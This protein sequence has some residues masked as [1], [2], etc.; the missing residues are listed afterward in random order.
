MFL[1]YELE[2]D[3]MGLKVQPMSVTI[4]KDKQNLI[5]ISIGGGAPH[6]PCLFV[7][8]VFDNTPAAKVGTLESG[9]E[10][11]SIQTQSVKG[12]SKQE[13]AKM[14]QS[15]RG[16]VNIGF[17]KL[18]CPDLNE[19]KSIDIIM[20]KL[21]HRMVESMSSQTADALGLSRAIL[22]N[23]TLIKKF[24]E[25]EKTSSMYKGLLEH[26]KILLRGYFQLA[27]AH[28]LFGDVFSTIGAREPQHVASE[29]F[30]KYA[31]S[32]RSIEK[33]GIK[34]L[35]TLKPMVSDLET[36]LTKAIPDTKL[37][38]K[39]YADVKFEYLS[40]CLK[41]KEM[42]D[43]DYAYCSMGEILYRVETGN[44]EYRLL[45]RCRQDAKKRFAKLRHD[46]LEK[47]ELLDNKHV[48]DIVFQMQRFVTALSR[49]NTDCHEKLESCSDIF[50]IEVDLQATTLNYHKKN[51]F[52]EDGQEELENNHDNQEDRQN[53]DGNLNKPD[54]TVDT[55]LLELG[56]NS[57]SQPLNFD[58]DFFGS[59]VQSDSGN[60]FG[61]YPRQRQSLQHSS[62]IDKL[63]D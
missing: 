52:S 16:D 14:I 38:I 36:Y 54:V 17:N 46:V 48:Q 1:D 4:L 35:R 3:L 34:L 61:A 8:Q 5:G 43:E 24:E 11:L 59:A 19:G 31:D 21:K 22:C 49:Y 6:C 10:I 51:D 33:F 62:E 44:Y 39:R 40:Y 30:R 20:K 13:V 58:A 42:D 57:A 45:L 9:D 2:E 27:H 56:E 37:T 55:E 29:S 18:V 53:N 63:L 50:P 25:L 41:I 26:C 60:P 7:V 15:V 47:L 32:H 12:K 28:K 23:D